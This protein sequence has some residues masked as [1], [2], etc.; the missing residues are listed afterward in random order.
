M[1]WSST[2][3]SFTE[4]GS[5]ASIAS[6]AFTHTF[7]GR[8][9][10]LYTFGER[11]CSILSLNVNSKCAIPGQPRTGNRPFAELVE[12]AVGIENTFRCKSCT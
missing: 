8:Y 5:I 2:P 1:S 12:D 4:Q 10:T 6:V 11:R 9:V 7:P 3:E